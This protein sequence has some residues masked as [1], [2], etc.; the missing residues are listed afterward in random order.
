M[1][2]EEVQMISFKVIASSGDAFDEFVKAVKAASDYDFA[3]A[4][5]HLKSGEAS[6][7]EAHQEQTALLNAEVRGEELPFSIILIHSQ[8]HLM[9]AMTYEQNAKDMIQMYKALQ[10][11][12]EMQAESIQPRVVH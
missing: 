7:I 8:D 2:K 10:A 6:M 3:G 4:E 9:H 12:S 5:A 1:T 11:S